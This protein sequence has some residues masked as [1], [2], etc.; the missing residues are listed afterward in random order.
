MTS[1]RLEEAAMS[2]RTEAEVRTL[3]ML[4]AIEKRAD[5]LHAQIAKLVKQRDAYRDALIEAE[6]ALEGHEDVIDG[7]EGQQL[8]NAAMKALT[9]IRRVI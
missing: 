9:A 1:P 8:P 4:A 6:F 3:Q 7:P 5:E 2:T